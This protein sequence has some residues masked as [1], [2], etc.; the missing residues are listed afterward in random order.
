MIDDAERY[1]V[2][3]PAQNLAAKGNTDVWTTNV[4]VGQ[5]GDQGGSWS[6]GF[7]GSFRNRFGRFGGLGHGSHNQMK[8]QMQP[9]KKGTCWNCGCI[10]HHSR[11][12]PKPV[13]KPGGGEMVNVAM[14]LTRCAVCKEQYSVAKPCGYAFEN[15]GVVFGG[16]STPTG[17][18]QICAGSVNGGEVEV[19]LDSGCTTVGVRKSLV[20]PDQFTRE[21]L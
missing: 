18:L 9:N 6:G 14:P 8:G 20:K 21:T 7:R 1:Q 4:V 19:M 3:H 2:A 12:C 13:R 10:G 5:G 16:S 15:A 11:Q 17:L